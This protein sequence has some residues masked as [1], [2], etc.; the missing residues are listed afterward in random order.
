MNIQHYVKELFPLSNAHTQKKI[1]YIHHGTGLGGA[2]LSLLYLINSL[3]K[4]LY[5]PEVLFLHDSE[6]INLYKTHGIITH[7]PVNRMDFSHTVMSWYSL[8][9]IHRLVKSIIDSLITYFILAPRLLKQL[10]PDMIHLNTSTLTAWG[11]AAHKLTIPIVWHIRESLAPGYFGIRKTIIKKIIEQ[12]ATKIIAICATDGQP[13]RH[14]PKLNIIY[15]AVDTTQFNPTKYTTKPQKTILFLGGIAQQKGALFF[16]EVFTLLRKKMPEVHAII[17]GNTTIPTITLLHKLSGSATYYKKLKE[18]I[19]EEKDALTLVGLSHNIPELLANC[20][21]LVF[22]AQVDHFAR[23][24]IEAGCMQKTVIASQSPHLKELIINNQTGI[25]VAYGNHQD[26]V[27]ALETILT[28]DA[29]NTFLATN[30]YRYC[31]TTFS[32]ERQTILINE[33]YK[34]TYNI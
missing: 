12:C 1:L 23:P 20:N 9:H 32:L 21:I 2:P 25:L 26:W 14:S 34:K 10:N 4:T 18:K 5:Q 31:S 7:G 11:L 28:N 6:V 13:W 19:N 22:P 16:L 17:A 3:D 8:R 33:L 24:V 29:F 27:H 30:A 15:N